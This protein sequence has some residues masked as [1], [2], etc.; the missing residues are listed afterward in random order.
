[1]T[2]TPQAGASTYA[3]V[4]LK[5]LCIA[6]ENVRAHLPPDAGIPQLW[7]TIKA[8]RQLYPLLCRPGKKAEADYAALDGRRRYYAFKHGVEICDITDDEPVNIQIETDKNRQ[9][10]ATLLTASETEP[11]HLVDIIKTIGELRGRKMKTGAISE[12]LGYEKLQIDRW[13]ALSTLSDDALEALRAGKLTFRQ[14]TLLTKIADSETQAALV[15]QAINGSLYDQSISSMIVGAR[16]TA[17]DPRVRLVGLSR[18][19]AAGGRIESDLFNETPD[20]LLDPDKLQTAWTECA[21]P[22]CVAMKESGLAVFVSFDRQY[23]APE[24]FQNL[25]HDIYGGGPGAG[26]ARDDAMRELTAARNVLRD[27]DD[28]DDT[29]TEA[30]LAYVERSLAYARTR[31]PDDTIGAVIVCPDKDFGLALTYFTAIP[32]PQEEEGP[33]DGAGDAGGDP[34]Q[35][36]SRIG[37]ARDGASAPA[38]HRGATRE[39]YEPT[40]EVKLERAAAKLVEAP[41]EP[42]VTIE[43]RTNGL[44]ERYT[45]LATRGLIR[46][47]ADEPETA[48]NILIARL[49]VKI[50]VQPWSSQQDSATT[51]EATPYRRAGSEPHP[52]LDGDVRARLEERRLAFIDAGVRPI[53]WVSTLA[54]GEKMTMLAELTALS[55]DL[56]EPNTKVPRNGAR[57]DA[58]EIAE[59]IDHDFTNFATPDEAFFAA[60]G[61]TELLKMLERFDPAASVEASSLRKDDLAAFVAERAAEH[62]WAPD[63][64]SWRQAAS[65]TAVADPEGDAGPEPQ[66]P[67]RAALAAAMGLSP[68]APADEAPAPTT[69]DGDDEPGA[70]DGQD[71][72]DAALAA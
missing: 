72:S 26:E 23:T 27:I 12:A 10:A 18:Y 21:R 41:R 30:L 63:A 19:T 58:A 59:T 17:A 2:A 47:V 3:T 64:L 22:L 60:H 68:E 39:D 67:D 50:V 66:D 31:V 24:G 5:Q 42:V 56:V 6:P 45:D 48:L 35:A 61:K 9:L 7:Q 36:P 43:A 54:H 34:V 40:A 53:A 29:T 37:L 44:H 49:F 46:A 15:Q 16:I 11:T 69:E 62:R 65:D 28:F 25:P 33:S 52:A 13:G 8:A 14:A 71:P 32:A 51:I 38:V 55:L 4:A 20:I 57:A 70:H 1:M